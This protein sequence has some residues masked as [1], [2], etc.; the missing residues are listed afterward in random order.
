MAQEIFCMY[1]NSTEDGHPISL[2]L[3]QSTS[4]L[5]CVSNITRQTVLRIVLNLSR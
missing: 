1:Y 5:F 2:Q 4:T 3:T